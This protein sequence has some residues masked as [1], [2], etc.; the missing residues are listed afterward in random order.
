MPIRDLQLCL[1]ANGGA[2]VVDV[3]TD[4][5]IWASDSDEDFGEEF[6]ELIDENDVEHLQDYLEEKGVCTDR[7]LEA[8]DVIGEPLD[9]ADPDADDDDDD[10]DWDEDDDDDD[11][12]DGEVIES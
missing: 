5:T 1:L 10:P 11:V 9:G 12:I 7:E 6:P 8:M 4:V 2:E 3:E